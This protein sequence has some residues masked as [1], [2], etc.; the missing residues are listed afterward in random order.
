MK[1]LT[2]FFRD[3]NGKPSAKR[4]AGIA[5]IAAGIFFNAKQIGTAETNQAMI[6]AGVACLGVGTFETKNQG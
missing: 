2:G 4:L 1:Y 6:Y 5:L 3:A